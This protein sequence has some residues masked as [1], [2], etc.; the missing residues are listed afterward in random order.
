[1]DERADQPAKTGNPAK[2]FG[3]R[4]TL[5]LLSLA[6]T[7]AAA[8]Q[9]FAAEISAEAPQSPPRA[10]PASV[11]GRNRAWSMRPLASGTAPR[12]FTVAEFAAL[13]AA[14]DVILPDTD[15]PGARTAGV[16]WYLDD[17]AATDRR[18]LVLLR[19]G[20]RQL[21]ARATGSHGRAFAALTAAQQAEVLGSYDQADE[22]SFFALIKTQT[23]DAYYKSEMGQIGELE[24]VGHE[25]NDEF[26]G[27]CSH[28]DPLVH[29]RARWPRAR[30]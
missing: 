4:A 1:M 27:A 26:P 18:M 11:R 6:I 7:G 21:D 30:A 5:K 17:V 9:Q 29:S 8:A 2:R 3:R 13:A 25:F 10:L 16:H 24:W 28:A 12:N 19:D 20:L 15:T 14:V 23:I 22:R